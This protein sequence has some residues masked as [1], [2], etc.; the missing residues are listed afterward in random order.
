M[1]I[2]FRVRSQSGGQLAGGLH[3]AGAEAGAVDQDQVLMPVLLERLL[4]GQ[5]GRHGLEPHAQDGGVGTQRL[6]RGDAEGIHRQQH[7]GPAA[8]QAA[9]YGQLGQGGGL[10]GPGRADQGHHARPDAG[11][12][13]RRIHRKAPSELGPQR[14]A[15]LLGGLGGVQRR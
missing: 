7:D 9:R 12:P 13:E 14:G 15:Q 4:Q 10:A 3:V 11:A 1:H 8:G 5:S 6:D 2:H